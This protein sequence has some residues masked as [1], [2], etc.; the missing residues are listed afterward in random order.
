ME[1]YKSSHT[2]VSAGDDIIALVQDIEILTKDDAIARLLELE[3]RH[4]KTFFET[5]GVLSA[6]QKHKWFDP[7]DFWTSGSRKTPLSAAARLGP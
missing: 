3:E 1:N 4:E 7:F 6:I 5:G 2:E